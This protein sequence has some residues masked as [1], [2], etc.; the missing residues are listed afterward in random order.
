MNRQAQENLWSNQRRH[1]PQGSANYDRKITKGFDEAKQKNRMLAKKE[2]ADH[3]T[4]PKEERAKLLTWLGAELIKAMKGTPAEPLELADYSIRALAL[5]AD[6]AGVPRGMVPNSGGSQPSGINF[7]RSYK[8]ILARLQIIWLEVTMIGRK[9]PNHVD[10]AS[11]TQEEHLW[12]STDF[13]NW[14]MTIGNFQACVRL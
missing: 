9:P 3:I 6:V 12:T 14:W 5:H 13:G 8:E 11:R 7:A 10:E 1:A 4:D 2:L